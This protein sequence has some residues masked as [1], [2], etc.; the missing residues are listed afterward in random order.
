MEL[1]DTDVFTMSRLGQLALSDKRTEIAKTAFDRVRYNTI[2][3]KEMAMKYL[4]PIYFY[5]NSVSNVIPI[6]GLQLMESY[7]FCVR[8]KILLIAMDGHYI[9]IIKTGIMKEDIMF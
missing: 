7:K 5:S 2:E 3:T 9:G 6:I 8:V 1:D 4:L